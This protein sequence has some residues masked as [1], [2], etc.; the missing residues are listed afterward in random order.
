MFNYL[1]YSFT[2]LS[3]IVGY[4][5]GYTM[6]FLG[7]IFWF[8]AMIKIFTYAYF[9]S[10]F[11]S[12]HEC[13]CGAVGTSIILMVIAFIYG[14]VVHYSWFFGIDSMLDNIKSANKVKKSEYLQKKAIHT[15]E[16]LR[17]SC[18]P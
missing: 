18:K 7:P 16:Y 8:L 6:I 12:K 3:N 15:D 11:G 14:Q 4:C 2:I 10:G 9:W 5:I 1:K 13:Y 17:P